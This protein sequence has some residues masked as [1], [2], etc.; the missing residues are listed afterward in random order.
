MEDKFCICLDR[1]LLIDKSSSAELSEA[2]NSMY[3]WYQNA[4]VCYAYLSDVSTKEWPEGEKSDFARSR[5]FTRGWTL[6]ELIAPAVVRFYSS[7]WCF[8][9]TKYDLRELLFVVT[10]IDIDILKGAHPQVMSIAKKMS[11]ASN[12]NTTRKEDTAYCLMGLFGVNM[13]LL[14][15]EGD[16]ASIRLQQEIMKE[17]DDHSLFTWKLPFE[18]ELRFTDLLASS[19]AFFAES[20]DIVPIQNSLIRA[21]YDTTNRGLRIELALIPAL[22]THFYGGRYAYLALLD[23]ID[24]KNLCG[25]LGIWLK[26]VPFT[27][28]NQFARTRPHTLP[29]VV[30]QGLTQHCRPS[31]E[32]VYVRQCPQMN[33][34]Q[35]GTTPEVYG[36]YIPPLSPSKGY[37]LETVHPRD[38]WHDEERTLNLWEASIG[39]AGVILCRNE[40]GTV[41]VAVVIAVDCTYSLSIKV[42]TGNL[43]DLAGEFLDEVYERHSRLIEDYIPKDRST[44]QPKDMTMSG[45][46]ASLFVGRT[47]RVPQRDWEVTL[48]PDTKRGAVQVGVSVTEDVVREK[49]MFVVKIDIQHVN[50]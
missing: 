29:H 10:G 16:E 31:V 41:K 33:L 21:P 30:G 47:G 19:P 46:L 13:P 49:N 15:G 4:E 50:D 32:T 35:P 1:H 5:W 44:Y 18:Q 6:Q 14:Y 20:R 25:P 2:I 3:R 39:V 17:S 48:P 40:S 24:T 9:G 26:R 34:I 28:K 8:I 45:L 37:F 7:G 11:W 23:C 43:A 27:P 42:E 12:R 22:A 38:R 36:F